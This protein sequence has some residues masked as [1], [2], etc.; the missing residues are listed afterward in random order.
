[1]LALWTVTGPQR[2]RVAEGLCFDDGALGGISAELVTD[3]MFS[4]LRQTVEV[5]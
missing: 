1:M 4:V 5:E 2:E 3:C